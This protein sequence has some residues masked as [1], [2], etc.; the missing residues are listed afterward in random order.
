MKEKVHV[1]WDGIWHGQKGVRRI[2]CPQNPS[3]H[4]F[5]VHASGVNCFEFWHLNLRYFIF[6]DYY[7]YRVLLA[8]TDRTW[9]KLG[10]TRLHIDLNL[11]HKRRNCYELFE[12]N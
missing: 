5:L 1:F 6:A 12:T 8:K 2:F 7:A 4:L 9:I 3:L 11:R 10:D